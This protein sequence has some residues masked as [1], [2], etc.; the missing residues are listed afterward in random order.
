M[1]ICL[2]CVF[3]SCERSTYLIFLSPGLICI[4][5]N[6]FRHASW[7]KRTQ[8]RLHIAIHRQRQFK[9]TMCD[10]SWLVSSNG[11]KHWQN[12]SPT[13]WLRV[14]YSTTSTIQIANSCLNLTS[15]RVFRAAVDMFILF[16]CSHSH[17]QLP[18]TISRHFPISGGTTRLIW[19]AQFK[20]AHFIPISRLA[21]VSRNCRRMAAKNM[22]FVAICMLAAVRVY[23]STPKEISV[24][25]GAAKQHLQTESVRA[26]KDNTSCMQC[27]SNYRRQPILL[28][29]PWFIASHCADLICHSMCSQQLFVYINVKLH[30]VRLDFSPI[31]SAVTQF[32]IR[33]AKCCH[34][35]NWKY[36]H[37]I[38]LKPWIIANAV[39]DTIL[40]RSEQMKSNTLA[41][42]GNGKTT[43]GS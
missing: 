11:N 24:W 16:N 34:C 39:M 21:Q 26:V 35:R 38:A 40:F 32:H 14:C 17:T 4:G 12:Y 2:S 20:R 9:W 30:F 19:G 18:N 6:E 29:S 41:H 8:V 7:R 10:C 42:R 36:C 23:L 37:S 28:C 5:L 1:F 33:A 22:I 27:V 15:S 43:V 25:Y 3:V 13:D 31:Y